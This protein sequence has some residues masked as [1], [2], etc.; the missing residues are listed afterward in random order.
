MFVAI[1]A[2][3]VL[4]GGNVPVDPT[5]PGGPPTLP[6]YFDQ[7][8]YDQQKIVLPSGALTPNPS[9]KELQLKTFTVNT[10][11]TTTAVDFLIDTSA[12]ME[13]YGKIDKVKTALQN[14]EKKFSKR[15][16]ISIQTFNAAV[17]QPVPW[18]LYKDNKTQ[19]DA[20]F[21]G[22]KPQG[23]TTTRDGFKA[24]LQNLQT[25]IQ[26]NKYP[27]YHYALV[28]MTDGVPEIP[29][30]QPRTCEAQFPDPYEAPA[31]RCFAKEEDPR[32]PSDLSAQVKAL[33]VQIYS[34]GIFSELSSDVLMEPYL[35]K[36]L[37]EVASPPLNTHYYGT[38]DANGID[39][40]LTNLFSQFCD[41][42]I[43]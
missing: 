24:A 1:T 2:G 4:S 25:A 32:I 16:A 33:G 43:Q 36:L 7:S 19:V 22:L 40:I 34:I 14:L 35:T 13:D 8:D 6:P 15:T 10:C 37:Q 38:L 30:T 23:W 11:G 9:D 29:P 42:E 28:L 18:G 17:Q 41:T 12:S 21:A 20:T 31:Q 27:G 5:G 3:S 26:G 39:T